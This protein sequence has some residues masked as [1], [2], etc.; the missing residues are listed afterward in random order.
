MIWFTA[1]EHYGHKNI[2][3]YCRRPF[4]TVGEMNAEMIRRNNAVVGDRDTVYHLGDFSLA[5]K[6]ELVFERY[7]D[8]LKGKHIF[9]R[10]SHDKWM[11]KSCPLTIAEMKIDGHWV[12]LCHYAMRT[13]PRSHHYS[14]QLHGHSHGKLE[15]RVRQLD[16]GVDSWAYAPVSWY[17]VK[18]VLGL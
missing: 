1:D 3:K 18:G 8:E 6:K 14:V 10:G 16:V 4:E 5:G 9:M 7:V 13:W 17:E 15:E 11:P 2:I 12:V